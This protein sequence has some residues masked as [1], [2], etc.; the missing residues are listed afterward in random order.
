MLCRDYSGIIFPNALL[1]TG[2]VGG[3]GGGELENCCL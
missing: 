2:K 1:T 3:G